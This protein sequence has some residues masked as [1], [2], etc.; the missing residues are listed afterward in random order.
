MASGRPGGAGRGDDAKQ[1]IQARRYGVEVVR[2]EESR[3]LT[4]SRG[5]KV[6]FIDWGL[7]VAVRAGACAKEVSHSAAAWPSC[8]FA[9]YWGGTK[10]P[11]A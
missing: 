10:G 2:V 3:R 1:F 6:V 8:R 9:R 11:R 5:A 4:S 7:V